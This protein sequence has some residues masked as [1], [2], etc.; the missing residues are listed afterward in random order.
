M[1]AHTVE[2]FDGDRLAAVFDGIDAADARRF[3]SGYHRPD[4]GWRTKPA[5]DEI[6]D[7]EERA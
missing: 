4:Q 2:V 3:A 6:D 5:P 1:S 7:A